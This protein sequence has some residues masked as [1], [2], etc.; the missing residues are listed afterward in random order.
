LVW[1][2]QRLAVAHCD[3]GA[4]NCGRLEMEAM[5]TTLEAIAEQIR[6][7]QHD[8]ARGALASVPETEENRYELAF[9][10]GYLLESEYDREGALSAYEAVLEQ[11]PE[12]AEAAFRAALLW[13]QC[14]EEERAIELY[15]QCTSKNPAHVNALVNLAVLYEEQGELEQA[16]GCLIDVLNEHPTHWRASHF[17]KS[18]KSSYTMVYDEQSQRERE[19]RS[20][21]LDVPISDFEL[22]VRSRNCLRQMDIKTL[23]DLLKISESELLSYKN[24]GET[25]LSEIKA[26]LAQKG[27]RL[28]QALQPL[29][30]ITTPTEPTPAVE[31]ESPQ[32]AKPVSELELSVRSR[33]ALQRL[34]V[35]TLGELAQRTEA[36]LV[37]VKNFGQT[38]LAEIKRQLAA[39]GLWLRDSQE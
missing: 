29:E 13:D 34:G 28:G 38:S 12:H 1:A 23:G 9:L 36:E 35:T 3:T 33:K 37:A 25:S 16:E 2:V 24:F 32:M 27:L 11:D 39:H 14:G 4:Y 30:Q 17:F 18:V 21:V 26:M 22:S 6:E 31:D 20:A 7:G 15:E 8:E 10:R 5:I 19:R